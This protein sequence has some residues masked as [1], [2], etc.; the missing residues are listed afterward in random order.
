M[1][2]A[3]LAKLQIGADAEAA[4]WLSRSVETNRNSNSHFA[5]AAALAQIGRLDD[6]RAAVRAGLAVNPSFAIHHRRVA[7][8]DDPT[9]LAGLERIFDGMRMAGVPVD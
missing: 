8:N 9:Y 7:T 2:Y 3:G 6:A 5:L 4:V 1:H